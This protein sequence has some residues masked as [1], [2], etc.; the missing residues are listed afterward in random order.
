[1]GIKPFMCPYPSCGKSF[2]EKGNLK[3]HYRIHSGE[4]PFKCSYFG[5]SVAFKAHGHLKDHLKRHLDIR[6]F[7]CKICKAKFARASTLKIHSFN[8]IEQKDK[9]AFD[10]KFNNQDNQLKTEDHVLE[11][12]NS[13]EQQDLTNKYVNSNIFL[14][15]ASFQSPSTPVSTNFSNINKQL[16]Q[17]NDSIKNDNKNNLNY[18]SLSSQMAIISNGLKNLTNNTN[19]ICSQSAC[20][21]SLSDVF[22]FLFSQPPNINTLILLF[23]ISNTTEVK[24]DT[25]VYLALLVGS[26]GLIKLDA[27]NFQAYYQNIHLTYNL[28]NSTEFNLLRLIYLQK[29]QNFSQEKDLNSI[30]GQEQ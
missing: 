28:I 13:H 24:I 14:T 10:I 7:E 19:L 30:Q 18:Q 26:Q 2:N 22:T 8:H 4:K 17:N 29:N 15:R 5:C 27:I 20:S 16:I 11:N 25:I 21:W 23:N 12:E 6:P 3:T 1:M 9:K